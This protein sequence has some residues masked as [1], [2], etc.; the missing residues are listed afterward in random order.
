MSSIKFES[1]PP[2][3]LLLIS[4][5]CTHC[6]SV[7]QILTRMIK[8][9]EIAQ[10]KVVN[11]EQLPHIAEEMG[12]RSVPWI[13]LGDFIFEGVQTQ[14][15]ITN[16]IKN[17]GTEQGERHYLDMMLTDGHVNE[18][19]SYIRKRPQALAV[20]ASFM[21]D[22]DAKINLKLGVGVVFEEFATDSVMDL[23][24]PVLLEFLNNNDPRVR[25]DAC[26]YLS[27]AGRREYIPVIQKC[28]EDENKDVREIARDGLESLGNL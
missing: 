16:W 9:G 14:Q 7:L 6:E 17:I 24:V 2:T 5:H 11:L 22:A 28:L 10:L 25:G 1:F 12:V 26:H 23:A 15:A 8:Q 4:T 27:L 13:Q 20:V 21:T 18:V 3:V 19:I